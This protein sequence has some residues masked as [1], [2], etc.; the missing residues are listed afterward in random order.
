M[1]V[2]VILI[3]TLRT[4]MRMQNL[5]R[6]QHIGKFLGPALIIIGFL[7]MVIRGSHNMPEIGV[8]SFIAMV[9]SLLL[10]LRQLPI[11]Q[12]FT[13]FEWKLF[14]WVLITNGLVTIVI[15]LLPP[16]PHTL[17][18]S[19]GVISLVF[20]FLIGFLITCF[21]SPPIKRILYDHLPRL[22]LAR[23]LISSLWS[24]LT[25]RFGPTQIVIFGVHRDN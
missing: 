14:E 18:I 12:Q 15:G 5:A 7:L 21:E 25:N 16:D 22:H 23:G 9:G 20:G 10:K 17:A 2:T 11:D 3:G 6:Q 1:G 19:I 4:M 8:W 24:S 13:G